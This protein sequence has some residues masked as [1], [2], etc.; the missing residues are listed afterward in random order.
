M[1]L[2]SKENESVSYIYLKVRTRDGACIIN[3]GTLLSLRL[4]GMIFIIRG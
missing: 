1:T 4:H 3:I 2:I